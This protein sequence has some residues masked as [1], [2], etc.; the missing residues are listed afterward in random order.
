M[1]YNFWYVTHRQI[2]QWTCLEMDYLLRDSIWGK[3][4][5]LSILV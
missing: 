2:N 4:N 1:N 5:G 3:K